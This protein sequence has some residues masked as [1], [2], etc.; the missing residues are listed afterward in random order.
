[1]AVGK[2]SEGIIDIAAD[3]AALGINPLY[4]L[5]TK[6]DTER[7]IWEEIYDRVIKRREILE[8][9]FAVKL[10]EYIAKVMP[11]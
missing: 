9:N 10:A 11:R 6:D 2:L 3:M 1:M 5:T 8:H 7:A 4:F